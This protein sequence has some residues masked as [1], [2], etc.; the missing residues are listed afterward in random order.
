MRR[1]RPILELWAP[2]RTDARMRERTDGRNFG[3]NYFPKPP[4]TNDI[5]QKRGRR[6]HSRLLPGSHGVNS[7]CVSISNTVF[8][9]KSVDLFSQ[10]GVDT[11]NGLLPVKAF[12]VAVKF[13]TVMFPALSPQRGLTVID[14]S[15]HPLRTMYS[16]F[17]N[18]RKGGFLSQEAFL[19][20]PPG[21]TPSPC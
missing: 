8:D 1:N 3:K 5:H 19:N 18:T 16:T 2:G 14:T 12:F 9:P 10:K 21:H 7:C 4:S 13:T 11:K 20:P 15:F 6:K 17:R